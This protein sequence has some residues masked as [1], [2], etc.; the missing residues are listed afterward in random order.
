L[1]QEIENYSIIKIVQD[2]DTLINYKEALI[3]ALLGVLKVDNQINC[4]KSVTGAHKNHSSG[5][6]CLP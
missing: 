6:V 1:I 4:L 2:S 3:F 5:V